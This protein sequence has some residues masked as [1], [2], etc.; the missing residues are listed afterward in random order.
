MT[1]TSA[2]FAEVLAALDVGKTAIVGNSYGGWLAANI[3]LLRPELISSVVMISPPLVFTKYRPVFYKQIMSAVFVRSEPK[4][5]RFARWFVSEGT[6][7]DES[8]HVARTVLGRHA[9]LPRDEQLS[10][11]QG[12]HRSGAALH[13]RSRV[14]HRRR[15]RAHSRPE[16]IDRAGDQ[17]PPSVATVLLPAT[18]HVAELEQPERVN[19]LIL[20]HVAARA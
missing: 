16:G 20:D 7:A 4:A 18:K 19:Q 15:E 11:A 3:A 17:L 5:E 10:A 12:V 6:F 2:W 1:T 8:R 13:H 14:A 9:V